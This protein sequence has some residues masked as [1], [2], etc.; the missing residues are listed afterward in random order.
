MAQ[1]GNIPYVAWLPLP[2]LPGLVSEWTA[3][4]PLVCHLISYRGDYIITGEV[5]LSKAMS[6]G[7]FPRL[8]TLAGF[9]RLLSRGSDFLDR[10]STRGGA[11]STVWDV[12]WGSV[13]PSANGAA[14]SMLDAY[15]AGRRQYRTAIMPDRLPVKPHHPSMDASKSSTEKTS[16]DD[17]NGP[18]HSVRAPDDRITTQTTTSGDPAFRRYQ[19]LNVYQ[20]SFKQERRNGRF[21]DTSISLITSCASLALTVLAAV[22]AGLCGMYGTA[23]LLAT[24]ALSKAAA[25][26]V[27]LERPP[28]YLQSN[29]SYN[30]A[31]MLVA[32]HSNSTDWTLYVGERGIVDSL[33]NKTMVTIPTTRRN[34]LIA[35]WLRCAHVLQL[36][37]MTFVA[38]AKGWD[39]VGM[40]IA[41][42]ADRLCHALWRNARL[43]NRWLERESVNTEARQFLFSGRTVMLGAIHLFSGSSSSTWMDGVLIPHP[44][45]DTWLRALQG[46]DEPD[47]MLSDFDQKWVAL[48]SGLSKAAADVMLKTLANTS[49]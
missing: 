6:V 3:I 29:E 14:S 47:S 24:V 2:A 26:S 38:A 27:E 1:A 12:K 17:N 34:V 7:L 11:S 44:R 9:A 16:K 13:F 37:S 21:S 20:F 30:D 10:A 41:M 45:R 49:V 43:G 31:C 4:I 8:G 39:G 40:L 35:H 25:H 46:N 22:L 48:S 15:V 5:A 32:A 33:L 23:G 18:T 36:L 19:T 42:L 28:G